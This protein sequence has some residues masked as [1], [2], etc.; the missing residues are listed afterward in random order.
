[1]LRLT[2]YMERFPMCTMD[3]FF[4]RL[5]C[6]PLGEVAP[7]D[8]KAKARNGGASVTKSRDWDALDGELA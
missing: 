8:G 3:R 4:K 5:E 2:C 1:M 6:P 7:L